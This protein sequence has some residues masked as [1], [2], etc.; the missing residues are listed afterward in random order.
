MLE[1]GPDAL[2]SG[3]TRV[4]VGEPVELVGRAATPVKVVLPALDR[5]LEVGPGERVELAIDQAGLYQVVAA[6]T[7]WRSA[8]LSVERGDYP[9]EPGTW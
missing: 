8:F 1:V 6:D 4:P 3:W 5:T 7:G 2:R 9:R